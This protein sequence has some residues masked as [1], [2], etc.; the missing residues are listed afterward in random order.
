MGQEIV[1]IEQS[2]LWPVVLY[3]ERRRPDAIC[4]H[5]NDVAPHRIAQ[6]AAD[7][8]RSFLFSQRERGDM[9]VPSVVI[10][11]TTEREWKE[12][13]NIQFGGAE[14]W[15]EYLCG[16]GVPEGHIL[17][18]NIAVHT[19]VE[20]DEFVRM[21]KER[22]WETVVNVALPYHMLRC[23]LTMI[24][25]MEKAQHYLD[26]FNLTFF[27]PS[28]MHH[29]SRVLLGGTFEEGTYFD[30]IVGEHKRIRDYTQKGFCATRD[31][32]LTYLANRGTDKWQ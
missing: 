20:A 16:K 25:A 8:F 29:A 17:S 15:K 9:V 30:R 11:G 24:K 31:E 21:A 23:L 13:Q 18:T 3:D 7:F 19:G 32:A 4:V 27:I 22:G 26:V 14:M 10:N 28:W 12:K 2:I 1:V 5:S 6:C